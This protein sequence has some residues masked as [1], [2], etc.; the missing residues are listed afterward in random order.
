[1]FINSQ[2]RKSLQTFFW[3]TTPLPSYLFCWRKCCR[4]TTST[5]L[6]NFRPS[7][8]EDVVRVYSESDTQVIL[9]LLPFLKSRCQTKR[10]MGT[11]TLTILLL[12]WQRLRP[13]GTFLRDRA[14]FYGWVCLL[15]CKSTHWLWHDFV[16][17]LQSCK[18]YWRKRHYSYEICK[19]V[20]VIV[21]STC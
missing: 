7:G 2:Q 3:D 14:Q 18:N 16:T 1:M 9:L 15:C 20:V 17:A 13:L 12:V 8:T 5:S 4:L 11:A 10:R 21:S 19:R 6:H